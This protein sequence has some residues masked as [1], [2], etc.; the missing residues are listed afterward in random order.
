MKRVKFF[1]IVFILNTILINKVFSEENNGT[2][3]GYFTNKSYASKTY[4]PGFAI[5]GML[6]GKNLKDGFFYIGSNFNF[7]LNTNINFVAKLSY[8]RK[9]VNNLFVE[10]TIYTSFNK[11]FEKK[12]TTEYYDSLYVDEG[13]YSEIQKLY[14]YRN[15]GLGVGLTQRFKIFGIYFLAS[16]G[17]IYNWGYFYNRD[18]DFIYLSEPIEFKE[19]IIV[20][21]IG[22]SFYFGSN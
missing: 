16:G 1:L 4:S 2:L 3:F 15:F 20:P 14:N 17:F 5:Y 8:D 13:N 10:Y 6:L 19:I 22:F 7:D 21:Y 9:I 11:L 12:L 18:K